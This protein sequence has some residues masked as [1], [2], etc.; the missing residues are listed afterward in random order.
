MAAATVI[1]AAIRLV[2]DDPRLAAVTAYLCVAAILCGAGLTA[3]LEQALKP[4]LG[5]QAGCVLAA[6]CTSSGIALLWVDVSPLLAALL[7]GLG[8]GSVWSSVSEVARR[9]LPTKLRWRGIGIWTVSFALGAALAIGV[10]GDVRIVFWAA[11]ILAAV[12]LVLLLIARPLRV[13]RPAVEQPETTSEIATRAAEPP[14]TDVAGGGESNNAE[15]CEATECCGGGVREILPTPF[16]HGVLLATAGLLSFY[17]TLTHIC[18]QRFF[19][20]DWSLTTFAIGLPAGYLLM[21]STAPRTGYIIVLLPCLLFGAVFAFAFQLCSL[22]GY[23]ASLMTFSCGLFSAATF[24]GINSVVGELFSDCPTD[25]KRSRVLSVAL[26]ASS[27]L[28]VAFATVRAIS[29]DHTMMTIAWPAVFVGGLLVIRRLPSPVISSL[30]SDDDSDSD[31]EEL[32]DVLSA[33]NN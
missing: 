23:W 27:A 14:S 26:F 10:R 25:A 7:V 22:E 17:V 28:M 33:L 29:A 19:V 21:M 1:L 16:W 12:V 32:N 24:S 11:A 3:V 30:G 8:N 6:I 15:D 4:W 18:D 5:T 31:D 20:S 9:S 13:E 2:D